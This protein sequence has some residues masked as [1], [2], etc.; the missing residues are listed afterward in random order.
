MQKWKILSNKGENYSLHN[1]H[2]RVMLTLS[3]ALI[4]RLDMQ[5]AILTTAAGQGRGTH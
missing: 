5:N 2:F 4:R 3:A 1:N